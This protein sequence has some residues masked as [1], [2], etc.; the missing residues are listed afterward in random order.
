MK[1]R[2]EYKHPVNQVDIFCLRTRLSQ[3][4]QRDSNADENGGYI[5]RSLYFDNVWDSALRQKI[6][7]VNHREKFRIRY[8]NSDT[9][10]LRLEK[11]SKHNGMCLK[12]SARL[13]KEMCED[14][15]SGNIEVLLHSRE[16]LLHELY[17]K[18]RYQLLRPR[19]VVVYRRESFVFAPGN[20][21]VTIDTN[22]SGSNCPRDFLN[23]EQILLPGFAPGVLE[24][25]WDEYLPEVIR[26][27][28][29]LRSRRTTAFSKYAAIRR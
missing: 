13:T 6:D 23:P 8:Y 15:L 2:H 7:G 22:L 24:V 29:Q 19:C 5:V 4:M 27:A 16:P 21:R 26:S 17:A 10:F 11:K 9:S 14:I 20:V 28:V 25:K 12:E 18:M 1:F 3:V